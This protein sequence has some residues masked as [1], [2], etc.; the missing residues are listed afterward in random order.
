MPN[1]HTYEMVVLDRYLLVHK[2]KQRNYIGIEANGQPDPFRSDHWHNAIENAWIYVFN[3]TL[4]GERWDPIALAY[5]LIPEGKNKLISDDFCYRA[6]SSSVPSSSQKK[7]TS[8][9]RSFSE[10][11]EST[12]FPVS[13]SRFQKALSTILR[14]ESSTEHVHPS[15]NKQQIEE[16]QDSVISSS[17]H[18]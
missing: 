18:I 6:S 16:E 11:I 7:E 10:E 9:G 13:V 3:Y 4:E 15:S 12:D 5:A 14:K 17:T 8:V 1:I 2:E